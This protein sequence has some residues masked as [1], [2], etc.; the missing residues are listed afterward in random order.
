[1]RFVFFCLLVLAATSS[2]LS[3]ELQQEAG[4]TKNLLKPTNKA[5]SWRL[6]QHENGKGTIAVDGESIVFNVTNTSSE[7]W[8]VQAFMTD[9][10][11]QNG[12][13][14]T[15]SFD[16]KSPDSRSVMVVAMIDEEDWHEI[17]LH[18]EFDLPKE[19]KSMSFTF[20]V[21]D[22]RAKKNRIGF[23]MGDQKGSVF[24]RNMKL[25]EKQPEKKKS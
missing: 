12:R 23:V 15:V 6:E 11:L 25:V 20:A 9:L 13:E 4:A 8:H 22:P 16:V 10:D 3:V 5:D 1:M 18:E 2:V 19:F 7:N 21:S 24:V 17:G 14:Y